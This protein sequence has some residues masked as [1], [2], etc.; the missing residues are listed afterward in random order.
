MKKIFPLFL[1]SSGILLLL[2]VVLPIS[3]SYLLFALNPTPELIDPTATSGRPAVFVVSAIS[4]TTVDYT[5]AANWF[6]SLPQA[7]PPPESK[8]RF[9]NLSIPDLELEDV[10][11][12][13]NGQDLTKN[14]IHYPGTSVPGEYGNTVVFGHSALPQLYKK[15][16]PFTI[17]NP[18]LKIKVGNEIIVKYDGVTYRY[19]VRDTREVKPSAIQVMEQRFDRREIT[20]ITCTPLGTYWRRFVVRAEMVD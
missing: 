15:G 13:I 18:L 9:F 12:E 2:S 20:L 3:A 1:L 17:F 19:F 8:T 10:P 4:F 11:V 14:A 16:S 7:A 5:R 6:P